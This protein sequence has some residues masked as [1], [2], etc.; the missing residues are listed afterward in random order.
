MHRFASV[1]NWTKIHWT[2]IHISKSI[3]S[4]VMKIGQG[5]DVD[6][7]KV[8]LK[9]QGSPGQRKLFQVSFDNLT[10]NL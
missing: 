1:C 7:P 8:D 6:H 2:I 9:G 3:T 5:M 10:G 4:R